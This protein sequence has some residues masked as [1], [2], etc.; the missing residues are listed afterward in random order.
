MPGSRSKWLLGKIISN[1][2]FDKEPVS[3]GLL[4]ERSDV[5]D[6]APLSMLLRQTIFPDHPQGEG[7]T[8]DP[9]S[10]LRI[11]DQGGLADIQFE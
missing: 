4:S 5:D 1:N 3:N 10:I 6:D 11:E 2:F 8:I 7:S 9:H